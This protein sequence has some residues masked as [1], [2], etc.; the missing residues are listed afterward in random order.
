MIHSPLWRL[1]CQA[2]KERIHARFNGRHDRSVQLLLERHEAIVEIEVVLLAVGAGRYLTESSRLKWAKF[3]TPR[4]APID[5]LHAHNVALVRASYETSVTPAIRLRPP[6]QGS[7]RA[8]YR[9]DEPIQ[10]GLLR[11]L[12]PPSKARGV[13]P[14]PQGVIAATKP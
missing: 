5:D 6:S 9:N 2:D 13:T 12:H 1:G 11:Q 8:A 4:G 10:P 14:E 3:P 7:R